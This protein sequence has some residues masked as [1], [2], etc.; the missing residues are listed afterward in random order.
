MGAVAHGGAKRM[1]SPPRSGEWRFATQHTRQKKD[2]NISGPIPSD[3][4]RLQKLQTF[5]LFVN[6]F[7]GQHPDSLSHMKGLHYLIGF[8][9]GSG[10]TVDLSALSCTCLGTT[11][12]VVASANSLNQRL[13]NL[14]IHDNFNCTF[15]REVAKACVHAGALDFDAAAVVLS[16]QSLTL[17]ENAT[18][19]A[20]IEVTILLR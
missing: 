8:V 7:I 14:H 20:T 11:M 17:Q 16:S 18:N 9:L 15:C 12:M 3:I 10:S 1:A 4:G 2:N 13:S 5:D 6:F 19:T